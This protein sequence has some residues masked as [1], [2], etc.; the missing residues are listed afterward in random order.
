[1]RN[2]LRIFF[3]WTLVILWAGMIFLS[4]SVSSFAVFFGPSAG[5]AKSSDWISGTVHVVIYSI[6]CF[7][8]II[9]FRSLKTP[10]GKSL[11]F[12]FLLSLLYGVSD[13]LHQYFVPGREMHLSDW[14]L[15]ALGSYLI[16]GIYSYQKMR[17]KKTPPRIVA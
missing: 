13:E 6:L 14:L 1:M 3:H 5:A 16:V 12:S 7:L 9:A 4:S 15:D 8:L 11:L 10:F 2:S 17:K